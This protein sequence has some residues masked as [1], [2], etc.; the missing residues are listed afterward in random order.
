[1]FESVLGDLSALIAAHGLWIVALIVGLESMG[2]PL[3]GETILV[4]AAV[5]A[6]ATGELSLSGVIAAAVAGAVVG[7]SIAFWIG[8]SVGPRLLIR[9]GPRLGLTPQKIK[10]GQYLFLRYGGMVVF[11]GRFVAVLRVLAALLAG[12]NRMPWPKFLLFNA[13]G[14]L[15]WATAFGCAAY[16][17]GARIHAVTGPAG[18]VVLVV[19]VGCLAWL[20][21]LLRRHAAQL[22]S[23][24][25][26]ALPGP[27]APM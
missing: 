3:P 20:S 22:Q 15:T 8:R 1:M 21:M 10:L 13:A 14:G 24:A 16:L 11:F 27:V 19:A 26:A 4:T 5:Y 6:G 18:L 9:Y 7:D 25:E 12:A 17:L 2:V 23:E